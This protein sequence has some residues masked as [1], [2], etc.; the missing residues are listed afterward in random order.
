[1]AQAKLY[2]RG[3]RCARIQSIL[4]P[5]LGDPLVSR[6]R[7]KEL[8][9][10]QKIVRQTSMPKKLPSLLGGIAHSSERD[11]ILRSE[12]AGAL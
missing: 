1:M 2:D 7:E 6:V 5:P 10:M 11:I 8:R 9:Q 4:I 12:V 3:A